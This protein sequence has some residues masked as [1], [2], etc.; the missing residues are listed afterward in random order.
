[1]LGFNPISTLP[2]S[3]IPALVSARSAG[4][5][6]NYQ[7]PGEYD[8]EQPGTISDSA[9]ISDFLRTDSVA[10]ARERRL[11]ELRRE[12]GIERE[13]EAARQDAE[14]EPIAEAAPAP[15]LP[16]ALPAELRQDASAE[17]AERMRAELALEIASDRELAAARQATVDAEMARIEALLRDDEAVM[18][19]IAGAI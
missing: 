14:P 12:L 9:T 1:M 2:I 4:G 8:I 15:A 7:Y 5:A 3:A 17:V 10:A 13:P 16:I 18:M 6:P 11:R 19:L